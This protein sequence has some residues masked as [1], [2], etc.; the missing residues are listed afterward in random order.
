MDQVYNP[1]ESGTKSDETPQSDLL[2]GI[3][4]KPLYDIWAETVIC[5]DGTSGAVTRA[6]VT[7]RAAG[8]IGCTYSQHCVSHAHNPSYL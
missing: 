2:L 6:H 7:R 1:S 4:Q 8:I 5:N 3:K